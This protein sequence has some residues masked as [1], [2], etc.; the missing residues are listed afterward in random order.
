MA[1]NI[2]SDGQKPHI[3]HMPVGEVA[4]QTKALLLFGT[5]DVNV[6]GIRW[7]VDALI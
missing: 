5:G 3:R 1:A 2:W 6:A 4:E 7:N